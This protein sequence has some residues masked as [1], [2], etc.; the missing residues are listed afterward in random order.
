MCKPVRTHVAE[1]VKKSSDTDN[2]LEFP[3]L[4]RV[5]AWVRR[6]VNNCTKNPQGKVL[7]KGL[8]VSDGKESE[9]FWFKRAQAECFEDG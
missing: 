5:T 7:F 1:V 6:F 3:R 8:T 2:F 4:V 9:L